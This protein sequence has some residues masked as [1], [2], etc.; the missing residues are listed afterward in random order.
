MVELG[1]T[2]DDYIGL[3]VAPVAADA[4]L[5]GG[6]LGVRQLNPLFSS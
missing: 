5:E 3:R 4:S 2:R 1:F 6:N